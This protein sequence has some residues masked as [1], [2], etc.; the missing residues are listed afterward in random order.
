MLKNEKKQ[1][2]MIEN[3]VAPTPGVSITHSLILST[4]APF[5]S[6]V[7]I[8]EVISTPTFTLPTQDGEALHV[9]FLTAET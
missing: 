8:K 9:T 3:G 5:Q 7:L 4:A 1:L 2:N 6:C